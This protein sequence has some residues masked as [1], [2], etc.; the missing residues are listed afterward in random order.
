[1]TN[2]AYVISFSGGKDSSA[3]LAYLCETQPDAAKYIVM[4]DTGFEHVKYTPAVEWARRI[5]GMFD[6]PLH[7]V[8]NPNKTFL[9]MVEARRMFP[10]PKY[11]QCTSDLK[12]GPIEKFIRNEVAERV[13]YNCLGLR[14]EESPSRARRATLSTN[15][16]LSKNGREVWDYLPIH[17]WSTTRVFQYLA[18]KKIPLHP[19]YQH[20]SRFS[21]R[22]CIFMREHELRQVQRHDPEAF[23]AIASLEERIGFT[24]RDGI[25]LRDSVK[26]PAMPLFEDEECL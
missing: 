14:A 2:R 26:T 21:C 10:A 8:R 4:A 16:E 3:M 25:S 23:E 5:A 7:V 13:I 18:E 17:D 20:L 22:V 24:M 19:M 6:L 15:V 12:R 1:M 9:S 11:R